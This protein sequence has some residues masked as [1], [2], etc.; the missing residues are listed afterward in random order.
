MSDLRPLVAERFAKITIPKSFGRPV[1]LEWLPISKLVVD[2]TYQRDINGRGRTNVRKIATQFNWS[3][4]APVVVAA[5]GSGKFAIVDGQHRTTAALICGVDKV[6]CAIIEAARAE[7]AAAF[8]AINGN[9]T[10]LNS[11][12][13]HQ[14]AVAAGEKPARLIESV[15]KRADCI[16][17]RYP[18]DL[19][20]IQPGETMAVKTIARSIARFG[21]D[22][23]ITALKTIRETGEGNAG[24]LRS[25]IIWGVAEVLADH[26]EWVKQGGALLEAFDCI[27]LADMLADA[28]AAAARLRGSSITDQFESRLVT[29][30]AD[31]FGKRRAA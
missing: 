12:Q 29:E 22:T 7:Q 6:P 15:C 4:F 28:S 10:A 17:L 18:K 24:L 19:N 27:D 30:L 26:P 25:Q 1:K 14:A 23:V 2:P 3:M 9:V 5:A 20:S 21:E 16:V 31:F 8:R 11:L 13:I